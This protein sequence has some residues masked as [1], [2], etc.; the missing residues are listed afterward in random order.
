MEEN[1]NQSAEKADK[2][3]NKPQESVVAEKDR[4]IQQSEKI[5][6]LKSVLK[7]DFDKMVKDGI[8]SESFNMEQ[9]A[10]R[11]DIIA[12]YSN[13]DDITRW[14]FIAG[15]DDLESLV[16]ALNPRGHRE[17]MLREA[18]QLDFKYLSKTV[19][20]CPFKEENV[21]PKKVQKPRSRKQQAVDKSRFKNTEDFVEANLRDQILDLE[22]RLWQ[23]GLGAIKVEDRVAWRAKVENDIYGH[24]RT[25]EV[26]NKE[27]GVNGVK[28]NE[29][30][31]ETVGDVSMKEEEKK[32]ETLVNG[33]N[34]KPID[35]KVTI[36]EE[37]EAVLTN[38]DLDG[39]EL[40]TEPE[41][42][43]VEESKESVSDKSVFKA[44]PPHM[45][46]DLGG[47]RT[48]FS[49]PESRTGTPVISLAP[50]FE[51]TNPAVKELALA[52][53]KVC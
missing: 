8:M 20:K 11:S 50:N 36:K 1:E 30:K 22:D 17:R 45:K 25:V 53:L 29:E 19:E 24:L 31:T 4:G 51:H 49:P 6:G 12:K 9:K 39:S 37:K 34:D 5:T 48:S 21:V 38:G 18:L 42:V 13:R 27:E 43:K 52:L 33:M 47:V 26:E 46:L 32:D 15:I 2:D 7:S 40:D 3:E 16:K 28:E 41:L 35:E 44:I 14:S 10:K 23:G